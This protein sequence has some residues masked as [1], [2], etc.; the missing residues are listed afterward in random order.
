MADIDLT[1]VVYDP[2]VGVSIIEEMTA[3]LLHKAVKNPL[4]T[5][6][7]WTPCYCNAYDLAGG[8]SLYVPLVLPGAKVEVCCI[9]P[10]I[11]CSFDIKDG[12]DSTVFQSVFTFSEPMKSPGA[13]PPTVVLDAVADPFRQVILR[14]RDQIRA[15]TCFYRLIGGE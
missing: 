9:S 5:G 10:L 4:F 3:D 7:T 1:Q 15:F 8:I 14:C 2:A 11:L 12:K 13:H 6:Y